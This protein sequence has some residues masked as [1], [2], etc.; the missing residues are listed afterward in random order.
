MDICK[1]CKHK[2]KDSDGCE[3]LGDFLGIIFHNQK[4]HGFKIKYE[5]IE[6]CYSFMEVK[7]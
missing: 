7:K 4:E 1:K 6:Y 5:L 3:L 2:E